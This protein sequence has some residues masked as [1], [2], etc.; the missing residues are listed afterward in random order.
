MGQFRARLSLIII[1]LGLGGL[2]VVTRLFVVQ[3]LE[4]KRYAERSRD[5]TETRRMLSARRGAILDR[6]GVVLASSVENAGFIKP[7]DLGLNPKKTESQSQIRR[8]YPLGPA[9]GA[10]LGYVGTD[11]YGLSGIEYAFDNTLRGEDGW[12]IL[13]K[14]G[15][16]QKY[17]KLG[18]P[19]KEPVNG[20]NIYLTI[21]NNVQKIAQNV[22]RQTVNSL[23]A[24][25]GMCIIMDPV[26]GRILAMANE[27][28]FDP[29]IPGNF[30]GSQRQNKCIGAVYEPGST[31]KLVTAAAAMQEKIK[32][33][34][35]IIY[36][37][38]GVFEIYKQTIRDHN[39]YGNLTFSKA[40]SYSSNVCFAK[41]A[42]EIGND[43]LYRYIRDFGF[44]TKTEIDL[45]GEESGIVHPIKS[46]SGRSLVTIAMGQE[47][48]VTLLQMLMPF[49]VV[50]NGGI[51]VKPAICEKI[52]N[53]KNEIIESMRFQPVRRVI[54][55]DV[56]SRLRMMLKSV[57]EDGTGKNARIEGISVA[58]KT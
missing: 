13:Q 10:L 1:I 39:P 11:G 54:S 15:R 58:G 2:S 45:P 55:E 17:R 5:Q 42:S 14:D 3:V 29:N 50:A 9:A 36:G 4:N 7:V 19:S 56:A 16:N 30:S 12:I 25:G 52:I 24:K 37:N 32:S 26:S 38:N 48:S 35:D 20:N 44:G 47:I 46:W 28:S 40:L 31:F 27:P 41:I 6:N 49:A 8:V 51:L 43:K 22:L 21:D 53:Q 34:Q 33:E 18:L 57:V 23:E